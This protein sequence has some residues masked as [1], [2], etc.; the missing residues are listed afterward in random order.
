MQIVITK[1][2][3]EKSIR[4]ED[5]LSKFRDG[6]QEILDWIKG[7]RFAILSLSSKLTVQMKPETK[8]MNG[9]G[10]AEQ[11]SHII[12]SYPSVLKGLVTGYLTILLS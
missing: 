3:I 6:F 4:A 10:Q 7:V 8:Y 5:W 12:Q 11:I 2:L 9:S 1:L